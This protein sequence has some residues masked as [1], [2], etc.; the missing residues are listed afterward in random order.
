MTEDDEKRTP[1]L[2]AAAL[3]A[4]W[5][6][7]GVANLKKSRRRI[8][9]EKKDGTVEQVQPEALIGGLAKVAAL[10]LEHRSADTGAKTCVKCSVPI[11]KSKNG[12]R[13]YCRK[14][15]RQLAREH[16]RKYGK[17]HPERER[18]KKRR[19]KK[20][21]ADRIRA[22]EKAYRATKVVRERE[23]L[24]NRESRAK[25]PDIERERWANRRDRTNAA[26]R[27]RYAERK[28]R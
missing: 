6:R 14:C 25:N 16:R 20:K 22:R 5:V 26:R 21:H 18:A 17:N 11:E 27:A 9:V 28:S 2:E 15:V 12:I 3:V 4:P 7:D 23:A 8:F 19:F 1:H 24:R 10:N 13:K